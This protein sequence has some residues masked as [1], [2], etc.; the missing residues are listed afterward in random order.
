VESALLGGTP[1]KRVVALIVRMMSLLTAS[2]WL[3]E[4]A[5]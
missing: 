1:G 4:R 5:I 2:M 3:E